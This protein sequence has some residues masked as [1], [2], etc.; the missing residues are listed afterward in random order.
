[1]AA[2]LTRA[3]SD[4]SGKICVV[5]GGGSGI[6]RGIAMALAAEGARVAVLDRNEA[7]AQET[8][9]L[10]TAM[11]AAG[12][13][14]ACDVSDEARVVAACG[15]V[16]ERLGDA[17][18][19]VNNAAMIRPSALADTTV[20]DWNALLSVN[21]T[22]YFICAQVF[23]RAMREKGD[24]ALVH[25]SS[26]AAEV[27]TPNSGAYG[28]A[29]AGV[30]MLSRLL[31]VEWGPVGVRSNAVLP[32]LINTPM[33][34]PVYDRPGVTERRLQTVPSRRI[35]RPDDIAQ[36]VVFLAGARAAYVNGAELV[37]DGGFSHNLMASVPFAGAHLAASSQGSNTR[38][39]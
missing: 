6:G 31:A 36:A 17:Q 4:L 14:L 33:T 32:G 3:Q 21:L 29:K 2:M 11:G 19:L 13:A 26:V 37:V 25:V 22:G 20:A 28:V 15:V 8:L 34:Q 9:A 16:R 39:G 24:G 35:G 30:S 23:G 10:M 27:A 5:T 38:A 18:V 1:M 7:G 12:I